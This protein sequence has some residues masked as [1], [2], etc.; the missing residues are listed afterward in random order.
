MIERNIIC[1][2]PIVEEK[3]RWKGHSNDGRGAVFGLFELAKG[4][5]L[6]YILYTVDFDLDLNNQNEDYKTH[7]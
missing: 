4:S 2:Q 3:N 6:K 7:L 5:V 1:K